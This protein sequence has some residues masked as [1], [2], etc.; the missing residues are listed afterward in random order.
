MAK[1]GKREIAIGELKLKAPDL[2]EARLSVDSKKRCYE[3][4]LAILRYRLFSI[5]PGAEITVQGLFSDK[6][7]PSIVL[8][9][10]LLGNTAS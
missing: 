1:S 4:Q 5:L 3:A 6:V 9:E 8:I 2:Q 10:T 7:L